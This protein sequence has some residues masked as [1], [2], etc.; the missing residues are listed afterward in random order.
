MAAVT[1][2]KPGSDLELQL[3]FPTQFAEAYAEFD[4]PLGYAPSRKLIHAIDYAGDDLQARWHEIKR[5][6]ANAS[7]RNGVQQTRNARN[8]ANVSHAGYWEMPKPVLGQR[9]Y[10]NPSLG[11]G[12]SD[13]YPARRDESDAPFRCREDGLV[14]GVLRSRTGQEYGKKIL[15]DRIAQLNAID[16]AKAGLEMGEPMRDFAAVEPTEQGVEDMEIT[17][18]KIKLKNLMNLMISAVSGSVKNVG[19]FAASDASDLVLLTIR[20]APKLNREELEDVM[21][22]MDEADE[23]IRE[24]MDEVAEAVGGPDEA[25]ESASSVGI[26]EAMSVMDA[27]VYVYALYDMIPKLRSYVATMLGGVDRSA[28][29]R[30]AL[31]KNAV[32]STGLSKLE[33]LTKAKVGAMFDD[34]AREVQGTAQFTRTAPTREDSLWSESTRG[35]RVSFDPSVRSRFG[36]R[37]GSWF[38]EDFGAADSVSGSTRSGTSSSSSSG[39]GFGPW[40]DRYGMR[41]TRTMFSEA[42]SSESSAPPPPPSTPRNAFRRMNTRDELGMAL[43]REAPTPSMTMS[44]PPSTPSGY[45]EWER[46]SIENAYGMGKKKGKGPAASKA[47]RAVKESVTSADIAAIMA[48]LMPLLAPAEAREMLALQKDVDARLGHGDEDAALD[49]LVKRATELWAKHRGGKKASKKRSGL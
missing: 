43:R 3:S 29:D 21:E 30:L 47:A 13:I 31:S 34:A 5:A 36:D 42:G 32:K 33:G 20:L 49:H 24:Q 6:E 14:G 41:A 8:R 44:E 35:S 16:E 26:S 37:S 7:V 38:G 4:M 25:E 2:K 46:R 19:R 22:S 28:K 39:D 40:S 11:S 23:L 18:A 10:A 1:T 9:K 15:M 27:N 45:E 12:Q 17:G 48:K